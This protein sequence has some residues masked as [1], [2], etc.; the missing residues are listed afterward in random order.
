MPGR[1]VVALGGNALI[2]DRLHDTEEDQEAALRETCRTIADMIEGGFDVVITHG[3]GP[4]V[5]FTLR[6]SE[7][8]FRVEG[9]H[10]LPLDVCGAECQGT[11]G[12]E[13]QQA[14]Q[15]E[16]FHRGI[17][18]KVVTVI[19]QTLV[20]RSDPAFAR[21][22]KPIGGF[23]DATEAA[24]RV[25]DGGWTVVEDAGRGWRRVVPSPRPKEIV[26]LETIETLLGVGIVVIA[27]GGG[28][29]PVVDVGAGE[30]R[31]VAAVIDK[32]YASALLASG[33]HADLFLI[34]TAVEKVYLDFGAP[35]AR[36]LDRVSLGDAKRYLDEGIHFARGSMRPK[37]EAVIAY[38]EQGG[39][40]ALITRPEDL[41]R[42]LKG[43]TGTWFEQG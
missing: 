4:Q 17:R 26:E 6:R 22:S 14:L 28:G 7:I 23:M 35:H 3:N 40:R 43:M 20:D 11:I 9:V 24:R 21:P 32:D 19:T 30:Y 34:L 25:R 31:G 1:A 38:L 2:K 12:Y 15:N 37:I 33:I 16:L 27:A 39:S 41:G 13:A 18:K 29:I 10:E 8:A 5:G 42:A 36:A